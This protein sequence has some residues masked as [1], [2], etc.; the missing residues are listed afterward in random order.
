MKPPSARC[1]RVVA[2][3]RGEVA[4]VALQPPAPGE[5]LVEACFSGVS[6]GTE[7]LVGLGRV[8][9][10]CDATMACPGMRGSFALP[11]T[12]GYSLVG[13]TADGARVFTMHPH[14]TRAFVPGERLIPLPDG[15]G[16]ERA[17]LLPNLETA[18]N[19]TWDAGLSGGEEI[20]VLGGGA[21]GLL[22]TFVLA[23]LHRGRTVLVERDAARRARAAALSWTGEVLDPQ[24]VRPGSV[25]VAF[26]ATGTGTGLQ[27][28]I[29]ATGF[30]GSVVDLSW[31]GDRPVTLQLGG[32]FHRGRKRILASQVGTVAP[33]HRAAGRPARTRAVLELLADARLDEL[34]EAP[35]PF[36]ALPALFADIYA[37]RATAPCPVVAYGDPP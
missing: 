6:P 19:A 29:D 32:A 5:L 12:Y 33:S 35:V 8:P 34:L 13:T 17:T 4:D 9:P 22:L 20:A 3:A 10:S 1:Y 7:R 18:L 25:A 28:A 14:Q 16:G 11:V 27:Q 24:D 31:Y 2:P 15:L 21:V 23:R 37:G 30:E 26:H 36:R